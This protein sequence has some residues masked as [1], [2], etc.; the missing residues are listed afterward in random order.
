MMASDVMGRDGASTPVRRS[1]V[2]VPVSVT[3]YAEV[4]ECVVIAAKRRQPYLVTALAVHGVIEAVHESEMGAAIEA[5]D[6]VTPDGQPVRAV[7]NLVHGAGLQDRVYGPT[8]MLR[9]C[10]RAAKEG[11][12]V[13]L[14]GSTADTV[15]R[16]AERLQ[17]RFPTLRIA[18]AEPSTFRPLTEAD[19]RALAERVA[20]SRAGMVFVGLGCPRQEKFA[21]A[22]RHLIGVPQ[23]CVGAAFDFHAGTKRQAPEW[24]Q[25]ASL[26][27]LF[28]L[29]QE[30]QRLFGRYA[31]TNSR[32]VWRAT[33]QYLRTR[34]TVKKGIR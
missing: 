28:R 25:K 15:A 2:G 33:N 17:A 9:L 1:V 7:L 30:P 22:H 10:E 18:G 21:S 3:D 8:L 19:S 26:E 5:F 16:L 6:V 20:K 27:W 34:L 14:Y 11:I 31:T 23:I 13:Y 29:S 4:V 12:G 24:M 32:F